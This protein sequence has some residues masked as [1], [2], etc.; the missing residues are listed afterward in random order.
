MKGS[1]VLFDLYGETFRNIQWLILF[2]EITEE[3]ST[4]IL[5]LKCAILLSIYTLSTPKHTIDRRN[6]CLSKTTVLHDTL[7]ASI[8]FIFHC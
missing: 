8:L 6:F 5:Q 4:F 2:K 7:V 1:V 3:L